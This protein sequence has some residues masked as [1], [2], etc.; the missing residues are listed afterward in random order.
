[1]RMYDIG[2]LIELGNTTEALDRGSIVNFAHFA[3]LHKTN[4]ILGY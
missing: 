3:L 1:M 4:S 2:Q